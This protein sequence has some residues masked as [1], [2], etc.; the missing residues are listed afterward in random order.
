MIKI[1]C[2]DPDQNLA[3]IANQEE[4]IDQEVEV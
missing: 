2:Q 1:L 4:E 3:Q